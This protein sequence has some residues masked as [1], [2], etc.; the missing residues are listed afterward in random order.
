MENATNALLIAAGVLIGLMIL[1]LGVSLYSS[2]SSYVEGVQ[3]EVSSNEIQRFNEQFIKYINYND[4]TGIKDFT[5][6]IQDLVTVA[7]IAYENN[8]KYNLEDASDSNYYVKINIPG[9][10]SLEKTINSESA[11]ILLQGLGKE[12]KCSYSNIK[13][14]AKT[15]RVYEVNFSE[16]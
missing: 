7:N 9:K 12:Y 6:T 11:D 15:G 13:I 5:L 2:L 10:P 16:L 4:E 3:E 1:S 14:S 8:I